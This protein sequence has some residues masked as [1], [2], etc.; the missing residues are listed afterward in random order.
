MIEQE[1]QS[2]NEEKAAFK[3][4]VFGHKMNELKLVWGQYLENEPTPFVQYYI[5]LCRCL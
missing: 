5:E 2:E 4:T 1:L 3:H